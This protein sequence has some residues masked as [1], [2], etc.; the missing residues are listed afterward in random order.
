MTQPVSSTITLTSHSVAETTE[1]ARILAGVIP[2]ATVIALAGDMGAGKSVFARGFIR[3]M[4]GN[5]DEEVP[6]PTFTLM[7]SYDHG[8]IAVAHLDWYRLQEPD[9]ADLGAEPL[10]AGEEPSI[11]L[12]EWPER[13]IGWLADDRLQLDLAI[14]AGS[15]VDQPHQRQITVTATGPRSDQIVQAWMAERQQRYWLEGSPR[16][17]AVQQ[18]AQRFLHQQQQQGPCH[19]LRAAGDASFRRYFRLVAG[20]GSSWILMDAPPDREDVRPFI[21]MALFLDRHGVPVPRIH[22]MQPEDGLLLLDD[23]GDETLLYQIQTGAAPEPLYRLAIDILLKLQ[24][25]PNDGGCIGHRRL[26]DRALLRSE[27]A[28][29]TDW[30]LA[31]VLGQTLDKADQSRFEQAFQTLLDSLLLQP[32]VLVH[33]DYHSRNL[34]WHDDTLGVID[35][36]DALMGPITYDLASLLRDCYVAWD[37]PFRRQVAD[38]WLTGASDR[39]G[40]RPS[41]EQFARDLDWMAIQRNLKAVGI[42][43]RLSLR[44]GKHGYLRDIP[45]TMGYVY[46]TLERYPEL[47]PLRQLITRYAPLQRVLAP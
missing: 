9:I 11:A 12:V 40:Y 29:F 7:N 23:L 45:R 4:V 22:A 34:M 1:L 36:Q 43:G 19:W 38:W 10:L 20:S 32:T 44:D 16:Q 31:G 37:E 24:A 21:D 5:D 47:A 30:Y 3:A 35:F 28:L 26:F 13:A 25:T 6:S 42:F 33:R 27:L 2:P 17:Q 46:Q 8:R 14:P 18:F 41:P 15:A 39:L